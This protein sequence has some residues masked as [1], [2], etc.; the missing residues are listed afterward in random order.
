MEAVQV[1]GEGEKRVSNRL[2]IG[3]SAE[4]GGRQS[5]R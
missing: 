5:C 4:V 2:V 3:D 1:G